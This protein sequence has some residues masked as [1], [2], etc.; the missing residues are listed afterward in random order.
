MEIIKVG[1]LLLLQY[2]IDMY[3]KESN[4]PADAKTATILEELGQVGYVFSDKTGT[5]TENKMIFKGLTVGG[6][7][8]LHGIDK[9]SE[10]SQNKPQSPSSKNSKLSTEKLLELLHSLLFLLQKQNFPPLY[11]IMLNSSSSSQ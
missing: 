7:A 11:C 10:A 6:A 2:D 5:L 3:H 9:E 4:T 8:F 1:Q